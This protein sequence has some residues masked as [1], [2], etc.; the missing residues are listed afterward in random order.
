MSSSFG[1]VFTLTTYGESHGAGI[2]GVVDGCPPGLKLD[3]AVIQRELDRRRPGSAG[4][5]GTS[6]CES[7]A[8]RLL[9][10]VFGGVTTGTPIAFHIANENQRSGDYAGLAE[11]W[12]P[13]H[14][15][16]G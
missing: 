9:S 15:D 4:I 3:E 16:M 14:A 8:V 12:R 13:G 6:R 1:R 10:G 2:G 5:A 7:D 11:I